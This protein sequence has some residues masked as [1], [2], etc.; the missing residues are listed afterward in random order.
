MNPYLTT[1]WYLPL[2][3]MGFG[4]MLREQWTKSYTA[5]EMD[6][7]HEATTKSQIFKQ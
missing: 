1:A 7:L 2:V 5:Q 6:T 4:Y 3:E